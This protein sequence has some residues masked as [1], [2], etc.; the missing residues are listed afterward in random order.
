[1]IT[2]N[3]LAKNKY[4]EEELERYIDSFTNDHWFY[5]S[6]Y[7][8]LSESFIERFLG[9][10]NSASILRYQSLSEPFIEKYR[11]KVDWGLVSGYQKLSENFLLNN[12]EKISINWLV[13]NRNISKGL[14]EKIKFMKELQS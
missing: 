13:I 10:L 6:G 1:M 7:Q 11:D 8:T 12:L 2:L 4:S 5:I 3:D 9:K 14:Y